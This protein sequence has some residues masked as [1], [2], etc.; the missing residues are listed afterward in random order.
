MTIRYLFATLHA[1]SLLALSLRSVYSYS[2]HIS[3][4]CRSCADIIS[5][6]SAHIKFGP[7]DLLKVSHFSIHY[8]THPSSS[9]LQSDATRRSVA[10]RRNP[11]TLPVIARPQRSFPA[12]DQQQPIFLHIR[13]LLR[14]GLP[15]RNDQP[16]DPLDVRFTILFNFTVNSVAL[17]FPATLP[18]PQNLSPSGHSDINPHENVSLCS[19]NHFSTH[20]F[21]REPHQHCPSPNP[22]SPLP[23]SSQAAQITFVQAVHRHSSLMFPSLRAKRCA[24]ILFH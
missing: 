1:I 9:S 12:V 8:T 21:S 4:R 14:L 5:Q 20:C 11:P 15:V 7:G 6:T 3:N 18:L 2:P 22:L 10:T 13:R 16:R 23:L 24:Q 19:C 17:Q